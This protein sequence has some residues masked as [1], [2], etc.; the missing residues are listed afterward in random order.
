MG[1][2]CQMQSPHKARVRELPFIHSLNAR[3]VPTTFRA[4]SYFNFYDNCLI[5]KNKN[6]ASE[7][8]V[9]TVFPAMWKVEQNKETEMGRENPMK[10]EW[11]SG[12]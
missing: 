8:Q 7:S 5:F 2:W 12:K 4:L 11:R 10:I 9:S 6:T 3:C 1:I